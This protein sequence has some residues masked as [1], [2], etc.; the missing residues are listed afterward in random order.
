M[1]SATVITASAIMLAIYV[2]MPTNMQ[3]DNLYQLFPLF[4]LL[5]FSMWCHYVVAA[6][7]RLSRTDHKMTKYFSY[8]GYVVLLCILLHPG[9]LVFQL[10]SDFGTLPP[11][12][13]VSYVGEASKMAVVFGSVALVCFYSTSPNA[14]LHELL[15][16]PYIVALSDIAMILVFIHGLRLGSSIS[17]WYRFV[18]LGYG[19][20][21]LV[22]IIQRLILSKDNNKT[23]LQETK[24]Q[25]IGA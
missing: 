16:W 21:L 20:I 11:Y 6:W 2:G 4:G 17:G 9:I 19:I 14:G 25:E 8:T 1:P 18:W 7:I 3:L 24:S 22:C 5:A 10:W 15:F 23:T 12:S 13:Y